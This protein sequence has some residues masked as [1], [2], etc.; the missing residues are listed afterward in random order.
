M[1]D[2]VTSPIGTQMLEFSH[3][4][5]NDDGLAKDFLDFS[6][7]LCLSALDLNPDGYGALKSMTQ[8]RAFLRIWYD[9]GHSRNLHDAKSARTLHDASFQGYQQ[10]P[11]Y[12]ICLVCI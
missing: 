9:T 1:M 10:G 6:T 2:S 8:T 7:I 3:H 4:L 5:S 12:G 11:M